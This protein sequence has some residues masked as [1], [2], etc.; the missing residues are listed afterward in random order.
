MTII[1]GIDLETTGLSPTSDH[2]IE[3]AYVIKGW[4]DPKPLAIGHDYFTT[5]LDLSKD[6]Q[7]L[8]RID[9]KL[10]KLAGRSITSGVANLASDCAKYEVE[11]ILGHNGRAFDRMFLKNV[12]LGMEDPTML[13]TRL[14]GIHWL[15]S[16]E[17]IVY[18]NTIKTTKLSYL[19]AEHGFL[20]PF[21][22][23]ALFDVM[24]MLNVAERYPLETMIE[25]SKMPIFVVRAMVSFDDK[26]LAK[27]RSYYWEKFG[28][29]E[30]SKCWIKFIKE[31]D[32]DREVKEAGFPIAVLERIEP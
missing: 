16:K 29:K 31:A 21:P 2:I 10:L 13:L 30:F 32:F 8:T 20:N 18:P 11:Y 15:D 23:S 14:L 9:A 17:D 7:D 22:H 4:R 24:T 26:Q 25:R 1:C 6:I 28:G 19:A 5:S 27:D 12:I 3:M